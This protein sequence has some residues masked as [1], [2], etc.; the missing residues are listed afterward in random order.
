MEKTNDG[1]EITP[2]N[3]LEKS[4]LASEIFKI[5]ARFGNQR[6][7]HPEGML[8]VHI[9]QIL[10]YINL[11]NW[12]EF[13]P[14]LRVLA[15]L[16]DLGKPKVVYSEKGHVV[17]KGHSEYS[18]EIAREFI[19]DERLLRLIRIHDKYFHFYSDE[20]RGR[21]K[22]DKFRG[23]YQPLDLETLTRF[24]YA[25]SNNR[26][27]DSIVWFEDTCYRLGLRDTRIYLMEPGVLEYG[28]N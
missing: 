24:N 22:E 8:G 11:Q 13:R 16:H 7:G 26:E 4:I 19:S 9:Q 12:Q 5:A 20:S 23:I 14:D 17:G 2:E 28:P 25:D 1:W 15:M 6:K 3:D 27:K 10:D 18:E 21:F